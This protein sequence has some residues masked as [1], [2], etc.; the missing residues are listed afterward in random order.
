[1][2]RRALTDALGMPLTVALAMFG[3][4]RLAGSLAHRDYV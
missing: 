4:K 1:M 3:V 2:V